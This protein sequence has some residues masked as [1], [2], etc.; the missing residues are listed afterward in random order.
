KAYSRKHDVESLLK[1]LKEFAGYYCRIA[2][3][4]EKD[5]ALAEAFHDI[6]ELRADVCYPMLMEVYQDFRRGFTSQ[7]EFRA[8]LR[9]VGAYVVRRAICDIPTNSLRQTFATFMRQVKKNRYLESVKATF[10]MLP[11]YR[12]FPGDEEFIRQIQVRNL[13]KFN[14][15]SYWLRR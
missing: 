1:S 14:R 15:R 8:V 6:R 9:L 2:L 10:L 3:G 5:N 11:S 4:S 7:N 12:R 13:Y